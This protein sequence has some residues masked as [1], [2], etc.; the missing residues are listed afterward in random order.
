M[1][2]ITEHPEGRYNIYNSDSGECITDL[3]AHELDTIR[4]V[5]EGMRVEKEQEPNSQVAEPFRT[6]LNSILGRTK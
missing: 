1:L 2:T 5:I 4:L 3:R 6:A